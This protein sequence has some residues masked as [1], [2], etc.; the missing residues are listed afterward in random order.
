MIWCQFKL[1]RS[2]KLFFRDNQAIQNR[3]HLQTLS[4]L[5]GKS[6]RI[7]CSVEI[8]SKYFITG[9]ASKS[10]LVLAYH[11]PQR[12]QH[13][14]LS[15]EMDDMVSVQAWTQHQAT[16]RSKIVFIC[17]PSAILVV[18]A[19]ALRSQGKYSKICHHRECIKKSTCLGLP[20][21]TKAT[22]H[23][24]KYGNGWYGVS[25]SLNAASSC[26]FAT[27]KRSK[28]VFICRPSAILVVKASALRSQGKYSK[29]CHHRECI[30]KS[31][32]LGLPFSTKA[33]THRT[34]YGNGWYG[35]S[36][37]LNAASSCFFATTKRSK[38]VFI[39]RPSTILVVK[40]PHCVLRANIQKMCHHMKCIT[41]LFNEYHSHTL[42]LGSR[43]EC[44]NS[45][46]Q[47]WLKQV[48][49]REFSRIK[50]STPSPRCLSWVRVCKLPPSY[51]SFMWALAKKK[52]WKSYTERK[53]FGPSQM[54]RSVIDFYL[55]FFS[56]YTS[57]QRFWP[58]SMD[59]RTS[60]PFLQ[61]GMTIWI[62]WIG[63]TCTT[64]GVYSKSTTWWSSPP[65]G[66]RCD[67]EAPY[68]R[69]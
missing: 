60:N 4:D 58:T 16:K 10:Q 43:R 44:A 55:G 49:F 33:T 68:S 6:F 37:S 2:I 8:F 25:S 1:E 31:T 54:K 40:L 23:R 14:E 64:L 36:S 13:T 34:K 9:N 7:A 11:S 69:N 45:S 17:R 46:T 52:F 67:L 3:V 47:P 53:K 41:Q 42:H 39:C 56:V 63:T 59:L 5:G 48:N 32:C 57:Q 22:T 65:K 35:V 20:F 28:I 12:Q 19:S 38:I 62:Y 18:K 30:K 21:S 51:W 26:F 50:I 24:T 29:I 15:M 61:E 27:T 66:P